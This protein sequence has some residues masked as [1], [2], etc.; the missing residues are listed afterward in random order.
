MD[1]IERGE[2]IYEQD[3]DVMSHCDVPTIRISMQDSNGNYH[4][5]GRIDANP[6]DWGR[7]FDGFDP[8]ADGWEDGNGHSV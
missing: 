6:G 5:I 2:C 1:Y 3:E 7:I 4:Y 8:V